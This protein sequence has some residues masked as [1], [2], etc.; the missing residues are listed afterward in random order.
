MNDLNNDEVKRILSKPDVPEK[1]SPESVKKELDMMKANGN[2]R[3]SFT[4][5]LKWCAGIAA[6][7]VLLGTGGIIAKQMQNNS[8]SMVTSGSYTVSASDYKQVYKYMKKYKDK[9]K[10]QEDYVYEDGG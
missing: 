1:L 4:N 9:V 6:C 7:A 10:E 3:I 5:G 8:S 2:K